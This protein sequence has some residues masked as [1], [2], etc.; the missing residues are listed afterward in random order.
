MAKKVSEVVSGDS[1][2]T[3][4]AQSM[5][6]SGVILADGK[7][8]SASAIKA[9]DAPEKT[10]ASVE[11][12]TEDLGEAISSSITE[13][14]NNDENSKSLAKLGG[15]TAIESSEEDKK[16]PT[17]TKDEGLTMTA[18]IPIIIGVGVCVLCAC[19]IGAAAFFYYMGKSHSHNN[20]PK[21]K[22]TLNPL[23]EMRPSDFAK[24]KTTQN[25][26]RVAL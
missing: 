10:V 1:G 25:Q 11:V 18:I 23:Y 7:T 12:S 9:I 8:V 3:E 2:T 5:A 22:E 17:P 14:A 26:M 4:V 6:E 21:R 19:G 15:D 13:K 24:S 16:E 20:T